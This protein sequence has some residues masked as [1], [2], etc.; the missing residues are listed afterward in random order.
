[1]FLRDSRETNLPVSSGKSLIFAVSMRVLCRKR[2]D[3]IEQSLC[4]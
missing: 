1:M 2:L 3:H 4:L